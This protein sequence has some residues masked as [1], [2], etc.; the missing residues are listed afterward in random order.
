M[1]WAKT[2]VV[3]VIANLVRGEYIGSTASISLEFS[4]WVK[5][6][7]NTSDTKELW[8]LEKSMTEANANWMIVGIEQ[9]N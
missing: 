3:S 1:Y 6:G 8:H 5:E 7:D 2:E 4:G 9:L